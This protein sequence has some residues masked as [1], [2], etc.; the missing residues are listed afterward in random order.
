[1]IETKRLKIYTASVEQMEAFVAAQSV[2]VLK[3]A[4]TEMLC[5]ATAHPEQW[6]WYA[7]W[8]IELKDGTHIGELCF[9]GLSEDGSTEISYGVA[10]NYQGHGYATEAVSALADWAFKQPGVSSVVAETEESNIASQKVLKKAGF[11]PMGKAGEEGPLFIRKSTHSAFHLQKLVIY[12]HGKGGSASETKHYMSFFPDCKVVGFNYKSETPWQAVKEFPEYYDTVSKGFDCVY[13][14]AN[15]IG[16]Y[17]SLCSLAEKSIKK[18]Y[19]ISPI[20][21]MERLIFDMMMLT[22]V[23]ASELR[24]KKEIPTSFGEMLSWKYLKWVR[25]HPALWKIPTK[26]LYGGKDNLQ[27][28]ETIN[29]FAERYRADVTVMPDGEHWFHTDEQMRFLD[30]WI[31]K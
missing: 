6:E 7:I 11:I 17:Y 8:M 26:I 10:E 25:E 13:L 9:K 21:D 19:F 23:S 31:K 5:G 12:I 1:M 2:D 3:K 30:D 16:A 22:G 27:S 20:V 28:L 14:I 4:Y 15:S 29:S 18:A 24:E